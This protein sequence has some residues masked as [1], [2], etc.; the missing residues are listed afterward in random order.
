M[1]PRIIAMS[2]KDF[3]WDGRK[4]V[5]VPLGKV[6]VDPKFFRSMVRKSDFQGPISVHVEYLPKG[7]AQDNVAALRTDFA[8][9][10]EWTEA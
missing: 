1:K 4:S 10:R 6:N 5:H 3:R 2:A 8:T 7:S 9:L